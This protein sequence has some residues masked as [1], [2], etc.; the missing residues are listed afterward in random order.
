MSNNN[1]IVK[2]II[3]PKT[4]SIFSSFFIHFGSELMQ[5]QNEISPLSRITKIKKHESIRTHRVETTFQRQAY[6]QSTAHF[7]PWA[8]VALVTSVGTDFFLHV[9]LLPSRQ[10]LGDS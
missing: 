1:N 5:T 6:L 7:R 2:Y 10:K 9:P 3:M 4:F 8:D